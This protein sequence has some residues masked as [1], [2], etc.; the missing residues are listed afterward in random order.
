MEDRECNKTPNKFRVNSE[1]H[2]SIIPPDDIKELPSRMNLFSCAWSGMLSLKTKQW[3][4]KRLIATEHFQSTE[5]RSSFMEMSN[6]PI[7]RERGK[8]K[9]RAIVSCQFLSD[10]SGIFFMCPWEV[11]DS[12]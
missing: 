9:T 7:E 11:A 3:W 10:E 2:R 5:V 12:Y 6:H 1:I 8:L 4:G